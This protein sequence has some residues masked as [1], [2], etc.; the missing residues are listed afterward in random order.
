MAP[1]EERGANKVLMAPLLLL[2]LPFPSRGLEVQHKFISPT[3]TNNFALD[4]SGAKIYLAAVNRLYQLSGPNLTLEVEEQVGPALD[5]PLCHAP[6]LPQASCE[7]RRRPTD[8]YNKLLQPDPEQGIVVVCGSI[9]QGFCQLRS[10]DNISAVAVSFP[11]SAGASGDQVTVFPSM[12]NVAANHPNAS[13]VGLVGGGSSLP[14]PDTRLLVGATYT[15]FGSPFFP[16]NQSLEDHRFENTPE[17]AIRALNTRGDLAKLFTFDINPSD[18]NIFKIKQG[19]KERHKL[20]FVRAFLHRG[21]GSSYAYLALN[22]EA[23]AREKESHSHSLLARICL[24][25]PAEATLNGSSGG[26]GETKKLTE[27]YIQMGLQCGAAPAGGDIYNRLVSVFPASAA[28]QAAPGASQQP[29]ALC[30]FRFAEI[31]EAIRVARNSCFVAP[32]SGLVTVLDSVVQGT[33]PACEKRNIQLQPEQLDCGAAHLQHPLSILRPIKATPV[34]D[35]HQSLT[36]VAVSSVNNYTVVFL[37]T[38]NGK[39]LKINLNSAMKVISKK[40]IS[41]A[42][43]ESVHPIMQ[44]DPSDSTYLYVMTSYQVARVKVAACNGYTSCTDCLAAADAYCGWCTMETRCSLQHDCVNSTEPN[45]WTSASEG[46]DRCPSMTIMTSEINIDNENQDMIIQIHG[47]IPSLNGTKMYCDYGNNIHTIA[48]VAAKSLSQFVYCNFLPRKKY[49]AFPA[50]QDHVIVQTAVRINGKNIVWANFTIYDCKRTGNIYPKT[51][52]TSC[53]STKWKCYWCTR[54]YTCI[55]NITQCEDSPQMNNRTDCPRIIPA[56]LAP[57]STGA[58]QDITVSLANAVFSKVI[59]I[60]AMYWASRCLL[61]SS[62]SVEI[63]NCATGSTDCSQ[64]LG[65]EDLGHQCIWSESSSSCRLN[66]ESSPVLDTC[67]APEIKKIEPLSGPREGGTLLTIRGRNMGRRFSDVINTVKIGSV[68]CLPLRDRYI[69]SEEIVCQTGEAL[70]PFSDVVT[71]NV[72]KEGKSRDRYSYVVPVVLSVAPGTG[73]KAGGTKV[74]IRGKHLSVGSELHVLV[75]NTKQCT[76]LIRTDTAI[77]CT[78]PPMETTAAVPVCVQ[79]EN[80]SCTNDNITFKYEKNPSIKDITPKRSPISGG[81]I[82]TVKGNG[83]LMVQNV[84]MVLHSIGKEQTNCKVHNDTVITCP[85]PAASNVTMGNKPAPVDFYINGLL[86]RDDRLA[87]EENIHP[88]ETLH[89]S[90]FSLEYFADPQFF[91]A[92]KEKWIKHHPGEPLTLVIHKEPDNLDLERN[93]YQVKIGLISCEIQIVSDKVI[94]CSINESLS[95]SERQLPVTIQV[96][97]FKQTIA[98][99]HLGGS[100]T[101]IIVSIVICSI[102]LLLSV[103][104][105]FVFC[106]KSRRAERY[107]QK[108]LLQMEEMESQIREEIRK[109]FA[110]LQTD[111]TDLTKEL[112][113]SQGIPFLEYKHFVTRTFFPKCSSLYEERYV[114]PSQHLNSQ[115]GCP[116]QETHPLLLG[117]WKIPENCRPNME[118]GIALFSTLLNNKHFLIVFVHALEQ[119]KDFAIRDRCNLASLLTIALHGKLEYYTSIMKDLLVDLI[120]ASASKNPK[121]MLRRTESVVEK[122]LTNWM[123]IC[124]YSFLRETVGEPFFLLLCAIKQQINKGSIDAITGKARYTLNEEWLL[125]ENIEAKPRNLNVSFQGCGMDSLSVRAM[126]TDTLS[127]VKEKILEAFCKNVPYSQWPR[128]EDVDLEWFA[129]STESYILRDLDDTSLVEDGRKKLNTLAHYKIPEGASLAMSLSDKKDTTLS[130]GKFLVC[131]VLPAD[132]LTEHKKSH[133]QSHRKKV[134]PEI[135]L[136]RLLSTKGTLQKFLDDLFKAILSIRDDRPP[137]AVKY[138]FDFLE[139]QAEK[140]GI[141]DPDTLHIW[142]TNSLPLRF[143]VN[144]LKNPQ[145]VFDIDKTDHIDACLS[146][147]AQAFIDACSIS[148]LQLGKD[149]PTNK[150]LY[151]KEIPEYRKIVQRYYKQIRDMPPLSEQEM[152]AHLAEESRKY[153][154]EFNTNVAMAEIY[155][156]AKKYRTQVMNALDSNAATKRTPLQHKFEQVIALMED[157]IYECCSEA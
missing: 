97:K 136:T 52:C 34:F 116:V 154:N 120:D 83:F 40:L 88:E 8:N 104:A 42:Y 38:A 96:G 70:L 133:R 82:I 95:T 85:S 79:F 57:V 137:V 15:G 53:L 102:L 125:R 94:H 36:S 142:K 21:G 151:A 111:M 43:G 146:V 148:D 93:E 87:P 56:S 138:F 109:G 47:N 51:A 106:T 89:T 126:D 73:P 62:G 66:S 99:L 29:S 74:T 55:S 16:R 13:T 50:N 84:S 157:N 1:R 23:N 91:T 156:Y 128:V 48:K 129:T 19:A 152:N 155:K 80:K 81:R 124:M 130:R 7:H 135:Y 11:P 46:V 139:E 3:L 143:W 149:S 39:L 61:F 32:D 58:S 65:R 28:L 98:M 92:K 141:S 69:V 113:R 107:W 71:V 20:S 68:T 5:N 31:E 114:L 27:S 101:A 103:V 112:N 119:Q 75:N 122:M 147:I 6:Q 115:L 33:G 9:Y 30:V 118:E 44:F 49:P 22:S 12:L 150:L 54:K 59:Q 77:T 145:F 76:D 41:V 131:L 144:I 108:T 60:V 64:C 153:R 127:Q 134:L 2:L 123:S 26:G 18:D 67:P 14:P 78:M 37:G 63:Y 4:G 110:E 24:G 17:I 132:E 72:S 90:K 105:L 45:F 121:L 117:E 86:Y 25:D 100:E 35:Y 140:R 10:M